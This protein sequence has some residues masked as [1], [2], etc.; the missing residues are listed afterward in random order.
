M[1]RF[2]LPIVIV[3]MISSAVFFVSCDNGGLENLLEVAKGNPELASLVNIILYVDQHSTA[4]LAATLADTTKTITV[5]GPI[6][7]AFVAVLGDNDGD[8]VVETEDIEDVRDLLGVTDAQ[9]ADLLLDILSYHVISGQK[10][11]AADVIA[12]DGSSIGP[13]DAGVN[14][15]VTV[16]SITLDPADGESGAD[17]VETATDLEASNGVAHAIDDIIAISLLP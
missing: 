11:M 10:L 2:I 4:E 6:N 9:A 3:L 7:A 1:K 13:T 16:S 15:N 14:L 5:F 12:A 17:I 8:G